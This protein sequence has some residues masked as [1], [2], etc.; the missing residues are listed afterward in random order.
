[1][2]N[3]EG[4]YGLLLATSMIFIVLADLQPCVMRMKYYYYGSAF[5]WLGYGIAIGSMAAI[6]YDVIGIMALSY[7][8][9]KIKIDI[10]KNDCVKAYA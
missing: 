5:C 4:W 9:Y 7:S 3:Q 6:L 8:L 10:S 2:F 1:M